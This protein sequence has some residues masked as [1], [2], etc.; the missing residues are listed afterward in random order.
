ML[1]ELIDCIRLAF[2][3]MADSL[4]DFSSRVYGPLSLHA[5]MSSNRL[6]LIAEDLTC[7]LIF[8]G[9]S[10]HISN[11]KE[12][13]NVCGSIMEEI[14]AKLKGSLSNLESKLTAG[15][16]LNLK[17]ELD[18]F[19]EFLELA[20]NFLSYLASDLMN[21]ED[22]KMKM[23]GFILKISADDLQIIRKR[24]NELRNQ[25]VNSAVK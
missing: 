18:N 19:D 25:L 11:F 8:A 22:E 12:P 15:I 5:A 4:L 23:V 1:L 9:F 6:R 14:Y 13:G 7:A 2:L 21:L 10:S 20:E 16:E 3:K 17:S 24:H